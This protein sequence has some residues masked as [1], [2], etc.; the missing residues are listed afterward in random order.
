MKITREY[1]FPILYWSAFLRM[2]IS[3]DKIMGFTGE[4]VFPVGSIE[5]PV[6]AGEHPKQKIIMVKFLLIY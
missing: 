1:P 3:R 4:Q 5:L 2:D 6:I